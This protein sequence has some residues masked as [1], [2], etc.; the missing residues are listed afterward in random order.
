MF[1]VVPES[2]SQSCETFLYALFTPLLRNDQ[3]G[4]FEANTHMADALNAMT[5]SRALILD[6][7]LI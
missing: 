5:N 3:H 6:L 7:N 2:E 1:I 4:G